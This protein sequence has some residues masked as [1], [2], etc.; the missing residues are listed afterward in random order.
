MRY[1]PNTELESWILGGPIM[2]PIKSPNPPPNSQ[3]S[4]LRGS[5]VL[6]LKAAYSNLRTLNYEP[7]FPRPQA[8]SIT[9]DTLDLRAHR[10]LSTSPRNCIHL[11]PRHRSESPYAKQPEFEPSLTPNP[12]LRPWSSRVTLCISSFSKVHPRDPILKL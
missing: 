8:Q 5:F 3:I 4:E 7:P 6:P 2:S 1:H 10:Q 9:F 12:E 11:S